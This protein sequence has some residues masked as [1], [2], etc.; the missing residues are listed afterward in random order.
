MRMAPCAEIPMPS[1]GKVH[2]R[3]KS[4]KKSRH[5]DPCVCCRRRELLESGSIRVMRGGAMLYLPRRALLSHGGLWGRLLLKG[6]AR[7]ESRFYPEARGADRM[8]T[9]S[10]AWPY[11]MHMAMLCDA[12]SDTIGL[13]RI[14]PQPTA[15]SLRRKT[16]ITFQIKQNDIG[17]PRL[18][19]PGG[20]YCCGPRHNY[21]CA[22]KQRGLHDAFGVACPQQAPQHRG[23]HRAF[24]AASPKHAPKQNGLHS[25][26]EA[27]SPKHVPLEV[28]GLPDMPVAS[29]A[30]V[31]FGWH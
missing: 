30:G 29:L 23:L 8:A 6:L 26:F 10:C 11:G 2:G 17:A 13:A 5:S 16:P 1:G 4:Q 24:R 27:A 9:C 31:L 15:A 7:G 18:G 21:A 28:R 3:Q 14:R 20:L 22:P 19:P 12:L 25:T